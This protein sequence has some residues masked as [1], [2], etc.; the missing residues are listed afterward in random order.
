MKSIEIREAHPDDAD[1]MREVLRLTWVA[2]YPNE[3]YGITKEDIEAQF[4]ENPEMTEERRERQR[5]YVCTPPFR[6]WVAL[7]GTDLIGFCTIKQDEHE[8]LIQALYI[9]PDYQN[10]GVGKRLLQVVLGWFGQEKEVVLNVASYNEKAI[11]FYQAFGFV[12]NGSV[13]SSEALQLPSGVRLPEIKMVKRG[14]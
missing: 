8:N 9:L 3:V 1:A 12:L 7:E 11:A 4:R 6:S 13:A 5:R 2:T 14:S 10:K